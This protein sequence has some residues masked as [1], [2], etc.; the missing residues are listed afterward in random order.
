LVKP[1]ADF[2]IGSDTSKCVGTFSLPFVST[3]SYSNRYQWFFGDGESSVTEN[4]EV[5]HF[6]RQAGDYNVTLISTGLDGCKDTITKPVR[7]KGPVGDL[8]IKDNY[9]CMGEPL[10]AVLDG[11]NISGYF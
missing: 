2:S 7:I 4:I 6:Y 11:S 1:E 10:T 5:S 8:T 9:L 3:S